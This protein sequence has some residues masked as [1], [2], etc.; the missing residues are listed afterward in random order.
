AW[1]A[2]KP[3]GHV[4]HMALEYL[5]TQA[6][7]GVCCPITMTYAAVPA[8]KHHPRADDW[9]KKVAAATYDPRSIPA[10][11]KIGLT[12]G[13]AMTE[14]QGGSDVRS[15]TTRGRAMGNGWFELT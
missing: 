11:E 6:E 3:S 1:T 14:K 2:G 12:I 5:L 4:A 9:V 15:N 7:P 13:M 10:A 8:F